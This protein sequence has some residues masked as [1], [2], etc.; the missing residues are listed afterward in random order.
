LEEVER[1]LATPPPLDPGTTAAEH[2]AVTDVSLDFLAPSEMPGHLGRLGHFEVVEVI[3]RGGM[4]VVLKALDACLQRH[5]AIKVLDPQFAKDELSRRRFCREARAAASVTHENIVAIHQVER[6]EGQDLPYLVMQYVAGTS[7]QDLLDE[8]GALELP[9][10]LRIAMQIA[11]GLAA[12]HAQGL[13]HRDIKPANILLQVGGATEPVED[14]AKDPAATNPRPPARRSLPA[15]STGAV[16]PFTVKI[17]DFGLARAAEDVKLTQTGFVAGTPLYMAPEQARG[18]PLDHRADLFSLGSVLY[19]MCTGRAPFR[20]PTTVAVL[21]RVC[22]E[23]PRDVRDY[24]PEIPD[25]LAE[26]IHTLHAQK[27]RHP[28]Q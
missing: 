12:A 16:V 1:V 27:P 21:K 10:I 4:G 8:R 22:D 2:P 24:N 19:A 9:D 25:W 28:F 3:G 20:A 17:T 23:T 15:S 5:V 14:A 26:I 13:I 7:L 18:E 11:S 6:D